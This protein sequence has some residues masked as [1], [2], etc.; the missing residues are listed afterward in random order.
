MS[1]I[2]RNHTGPPHAVLLDEI[3][4]LYGNCLFEIISI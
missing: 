2:P 3:Q 1:L 4:A